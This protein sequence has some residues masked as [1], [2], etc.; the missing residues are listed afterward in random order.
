MLYALQLI[1]PS[2]WTR[3]VECGNL[4]KEFQMAAEAG[5]GKHTALPQEANTLLWKNHCFLYLSG[6]ILPCSD[7]RV[8]EAM[9]HS[10]NRA[11]T[12]QFRAREPEFLK[13]QLL[14]A[15]KGL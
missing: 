7:R 15:V 3:Y 6:K 13:Q 4:Q 9:T 11:Q 1:K 10:F 12:G 2:S 14:E 5:S 8:T